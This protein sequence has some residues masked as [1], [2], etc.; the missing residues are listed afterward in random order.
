M[1]EGAP[2]PECVIRRSAQSICELLSLGRFNLSHEKQTQAEIELHLAARLPMGST[3]EREKRLSAFDV[4]DFVID[5][6]IVVEVK[7]RKAQR[8]QILRQLAR[9]AKFDCVEAIILVSSKS[10]SLP[11][12][13][14]GK[15]AFSVSLSKAWL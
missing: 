2:T 7:V 11:P 6:R 3:L 5:G 14:L 4:P 15:P 1:I 13:I 8:P 9:Y 12:E 10:F